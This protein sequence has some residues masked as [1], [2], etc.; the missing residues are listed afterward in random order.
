MVLLKEKQQML[1][2]VEHQI[3]ELEATFEASMAERNFLENSIE[4]CNA[5]LGRSGRLI[6]ALGDE[7]ERW[8]DTIRVN[9]KNNIIY[10]NYKFSLILFLYLT[11]LFFHFQFDRN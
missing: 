1:A 8:N 3:A 9:S 10:L 2:E 11:K 4:L 6:S 7:Q 5:R